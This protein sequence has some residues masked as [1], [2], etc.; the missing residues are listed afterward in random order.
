V[1]VDDGMLLYPTTTHDVDSE[2]KV[3]G[4]RIPVA[5]VDLAAPWQSIKARLIHLVES[6][7]AAR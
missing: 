3:Q 7:V 2:M 6:G 5:T 1:D 4:H